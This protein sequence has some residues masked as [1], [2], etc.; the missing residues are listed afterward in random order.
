MKL[1]QKVLIIAFVLSGL[2]AFGE[3][4]RCYQTYDPWES[5]NRG[6]FNFNRGIDRA[7]FRPLVKIYY[8]SVPKWSQERVSSFFNNVTEPLSFLNYVLQGQAKEASQTAWRFVINSTFGLLGIF[9][10][11]SKAGLIVK[12]QNFSDTMAHYKI[13]YGMYLVVPILGPSTT[14]NIYG[15]VVDTFSDPVG[16]AASRKTYSLFEWY[17]LALS[18]NRRIKADPVLGTIEESSIDEYSKT[19][20]LYLQSLASS[21]PNCEQDNTQINYENVE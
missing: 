9:D 18:V 21:D 5:L 12:K 14:R 8:Y 17:N 1:G 15:T 4:G 2:K 10:P 16:I 19:R 3:A 7:F 13:N 6:T 11:A 20:D